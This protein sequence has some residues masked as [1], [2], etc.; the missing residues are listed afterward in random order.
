MELNLSK[1]EL[2][3]KEVTIK[4]M[5]DLNNQ[6]KTLVLERNTLRQ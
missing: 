3:S 1:K 4:E 6:N 2:M 5:Q